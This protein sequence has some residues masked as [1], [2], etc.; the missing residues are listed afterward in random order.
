MDGPLQTSSRTTP[1]IL[2]A[3]LNELPGTLLPDQ[4]RP[5]KP[6]D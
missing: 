6:T 3:I 1:T 4:R 5:D 2:F